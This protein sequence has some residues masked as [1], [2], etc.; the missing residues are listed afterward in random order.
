MDCP[1]SASSTCTNTARPPINSCGTFPA[2]RGSVI[3]CRTPT[4]SNRRCSNIRLTNS[5]FSAASRTNC[6]KL[7]APSPAIK[8]LCRLPELI[9]ESEQRHRHNRIQRRHGQC[10]APLKYQLLLPKQRARHHPIKKL[11]EHVK[12]ERD[13]EPQQDVIDIQPDAH[14]G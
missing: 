11:V 13:Y 3:F 14:G 5:P 4:R 6:S 9:Q 7:R 12:E 8:I 1:G 2:I 10:L